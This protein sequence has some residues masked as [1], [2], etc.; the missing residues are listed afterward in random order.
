M[1]L[2][3]IKAAAVVV[4]TIREDWNP[5]TIES[6]L[7]E[8]ADNWPHADVLYAAVMIAS[9]MS[10]QFPATLSMK[11]GKVLER[12]HTKTAT[13]RTKTGGGGD[14]SYLCDVCTKPERDC[15][16]AA[17]NMNGSDHAFVN[18]ARRNLDRDQM[19]AD[20]RIEAAKATARAD[21]L[22]RATK[23]MFALPSDVKNVHI[24]TDPQQEEAS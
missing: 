1:E 21:A 6:Q 11:A 12:L 16:T 4:R 14:K 23:G 2:K 10:N 5:R 8:M 19:H 7:T 15:Q 17:T 24:P 22:D 20:G 9:D 3:N 13:I 18:V